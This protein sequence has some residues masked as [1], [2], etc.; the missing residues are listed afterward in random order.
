MTGSLF[1]EIECIEAYLLLNNNVAFPRIKCR[2]K[3][4]I[5]LQHRVRATKSHIQNSAN[6]FFWD[7]VIA[8]SHC[9]YNPLD[10]I[11]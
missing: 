10:V 8:R 5:S 2:P 1:I 7:N 9:T 6:H 4:L 3:K 11:P